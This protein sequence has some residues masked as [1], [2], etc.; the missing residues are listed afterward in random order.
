MHAP[1]ACTRFNKECPFLDLCEQNDPAEMIAAWPR[2]KIYDP[3]K[4]TK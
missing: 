2:R 1:E 3:N 4:E